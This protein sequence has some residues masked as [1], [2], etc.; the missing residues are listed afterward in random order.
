MASIT[1]DFIES[2]VTMTESTGGQAESEF[3]VVP[4]ASHKSDEAAAEVGAMD[5]DEQLEKERAER[6]RKKR[7]KRKRRERKE[8][9]ER[10]ERTERNAIENSTST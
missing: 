10:E 4:Q 2:A 8:R 9:E 7:E 3:E 5:T 6:K 1:S